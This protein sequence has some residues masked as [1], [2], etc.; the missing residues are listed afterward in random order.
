MLP[1]TALSLCTFWQTHKYYTAA[2]CGDHVNWKWGFGGGTER[3]KLTSY[4][5]TLE[6]GQSSQWCIPWSNTLIIGSHFLRLTWFLPRCNEGSICDWKRLAKVFFLFQSLHLLLWAASSGALGALRSNIGIHMFFRT[7]IPRLCQ[8]FGRW[9]PEAKQQVFRG[10]ILACK[11]N[12]TCS[13]G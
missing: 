1:N 2:F 9:I 13:L 4:W 5:H 11:Q 8:S 6:K 3:R 10:W 7:P 12:F